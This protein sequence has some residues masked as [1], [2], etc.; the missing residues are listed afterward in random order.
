MLFLN[1]VRFLLVEYFFFHDFI[2][3]KKMLHDQESNSGR[4]QLVSVVFAASLSQFHN[5][6][7]ISCPGRTD[8]KLF[9][10]LKLHACF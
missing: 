2:D 9:P 4:G 6:L 5:K 7:K 1:Q 8:D 3:L 10:S